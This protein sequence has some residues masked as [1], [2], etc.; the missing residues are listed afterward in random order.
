MTG[1][2]RTKILAVVLLLLVYGVFML[3]IALAYL[4]AT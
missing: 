2:R 3:A 4:A 1:E